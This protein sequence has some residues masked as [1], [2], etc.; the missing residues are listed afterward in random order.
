MRHP[1]INIPPVSSIGRV[2]LLYSDQDA[3][4]IKIMRY[5]TGPNPPT[6]RKVGVESESTTRTLTKSSRNLLE[7]IGQNSM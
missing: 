1:A 2:F 5:L 6:G 3:D 7:S 4:V